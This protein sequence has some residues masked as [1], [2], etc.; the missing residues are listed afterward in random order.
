MRLIP[1]GLPALSST[2][3]ISGSRTTGLPSRSSN[4]VLMLLPTTCSG[5]TA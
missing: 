1:T 3:L 4:F 2:K 5:G